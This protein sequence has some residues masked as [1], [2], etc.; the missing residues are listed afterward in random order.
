M[1]CTLMLSVRGAE[2]ICLRMNEPDPSGLIL[3]HSSEI[4]WNLLESGNKATVA[5]Q[6]S[7]VE[8]AMYVR[9]TSPNSKKPTNSTKTFSA[10]RA[11]VLFI[12]SSLEGFFLR[13]MCLNP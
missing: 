6:L 3:F 13:Q 4:L 10:E 8:C 11:W 2:S 12:V 9:S 5:A 7:S 1:N